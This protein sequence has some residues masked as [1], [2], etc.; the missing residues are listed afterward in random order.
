MNAPDRALVSLD[1][2]RA[3]AGRIAGV[4]RRTP[5][6]D[7]SGLALKC[8]NLQPMGAFKIRGACNMIAQLSP[9]ARARGVI[10]F[11][12]GNHGTAVALVARQ[13]NV[14]AVVVM[15]STAPA[16]K[17]RRVDGYGAEVIM[18][19]RRSLERKAR[20]EAEAEAR[21]LTMIPPFDHAAII[22]G[23]GTIGLELLEQQPQVAYVFV[24]IG[25]GGLISGIAAAVKQMRTG[26][27]IIGVEPAGAAKMAAS[28]AAGA[29]V[30]LERCDS[31][32]DGLLP[33]RPGDLTFAHVRAFVDEVV[34]VSDEEIADSVRWLAAEARLVA[35][36][37]GAA[38]V[39]AARRAGVDGSTAVI[40][41]GNVGIE[42]LATLLAG[43][44]E[45]W[46]PGAPPAV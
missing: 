1:D 32:A 12:S 35:E 28:L 37:S 20:A 13:F 26:V 10:T 6:V 36:P 45:P 4:A 15:P 21:G 39:A 22:A 16:L 42:D 34:T 5:I 24:P 8:E 38:S 14:P 2:I 27:R 31:I 46:N 43:G 18:V 41:G 33:L 44:R 7:A 9:A 3:A 11:S 17:V 29:P 23:T 40:S 30:T 25:G 19:G